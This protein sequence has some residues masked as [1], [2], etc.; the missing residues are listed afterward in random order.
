M[1]YT[2]GSQSQKLRGSPNVIIRSGTFHLF[3]FRFFARRA[4][5]RKIDLKSK[6]LAAA[7]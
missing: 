2:S 7:G 1:R 4:K 3:I 5:K 6:Y